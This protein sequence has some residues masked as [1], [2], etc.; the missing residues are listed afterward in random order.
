[1]KH[2][3]LFYAAVVASLSLVSQAAWQRAATTPKRATELAIGTLDGVKI[4]SSNNIGQASSLLADSVTTPATIPSGSSDAIIDLGRQFLVEHVSFHNSD[5]E[6]KVTVAGSADNSSWV[7]LSQS[8]FSPTD[9]MVALRFAGIQARYVKINFEMVRGATVRNF[10][11]FGGQASSSLQATK[12]KITNM[13]SGLS[14]AKVI[15]AHPTPSGSANEGSRYGS[16]AFPD[17]AEKYRTVI[18]DLGRPRVLNEFGSVHSPRPVR[19]E[20][21]AFTELPEK[22]DWKGRRSFDVAVLDQSEPVA[23]VEDSK[24]VGYAK[25][26]PNQS[27]TARYVALRWEPD[28]N[29]PAFIVGGV[30]LLSLPVDLNEETGVGSGQ[31]EGAGPEPTP[32]GGGSENIGDPVGNRAF[33]GPFAPNSLMG[34]GSGGLPVAPGGAPPVGGGGGVGGG[35]SGGGTRPPVIQPASGGN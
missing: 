14:G 30:D 17:S 6:G 15:Y 7:P 32:P 2:Q 25:V 16:F 23:A 10:N 27:V 35:G 26:K 11:V 24:G 1:M 12:G 18:Y 28:F 3:T 13:A 19:L 22:E 34:A 29:P 20:V 31:G 8:L 33:S 5:G 9:V 4:Q 21:F